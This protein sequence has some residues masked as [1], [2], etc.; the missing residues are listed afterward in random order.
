MHVTLVCLLKG[1]AFTLHTLSGLLVIW[2][3]LQVVE[4]Q[5]TFATVPPAGR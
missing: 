1:V 2:A 5:M 3:A 4:S